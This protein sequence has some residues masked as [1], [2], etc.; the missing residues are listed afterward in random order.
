MNGS[1][2]KDRKLRIKWDK[3]RRATLGN[4]WGF[5][6]AN[7]IIFEYNGIVYTFL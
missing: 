6:N 7:F 5:K 2:R 1:F 4:C 3:L